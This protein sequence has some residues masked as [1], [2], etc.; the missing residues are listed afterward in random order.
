MQPSPGRDTRYGIPRKA[1]GIG[2][3]DDF[4]IQ[5]FRLQV[6]LH[7]RYERA[8]VRAIA[9]ADSRQ[10]LLRRLRAPQCREIV[11]EIPQVRE[12]FR[13]LAVSYA[14]V[15]VDHRSPSLCRDTR[16]EGGSTPEHLELILEPG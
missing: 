1:S 14:S 2:E 6:S 7:T 16:D 4:A 15:G 11:V 9:V 3:K 10:A 12:G 8:G 5:T 13:E